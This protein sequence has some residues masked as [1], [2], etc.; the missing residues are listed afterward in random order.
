MKLTKQLAL[1]L[2][3]LLDLSALAPDEDLDRHAVR[4]IAESLFE[5]RLDS[6]QFGLLTDWTHKIADCAP[7]LASGA[8][9]RQ[10]SGPVAGSTK[11]RI[12]A[13]SRSTA[14]AA[15]DQTQPRPPPEKTDRARADDAR[16][17]MT[18]KERKHNIA[19][20]RAPIGPLHRRRKTG[21]GCGSLPQASQRALRRRLPLRA[22]RGAYSPRLCL[23]SPQ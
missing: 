1:Q 16:P 8:A 22:L 13:T 10:T 17:T 11:R 5:G 15:V 20:G 21:D 4:E 19:G 14:E 12:P 23:G 9:P 6:F 2:A 3:D 7:R 18:E